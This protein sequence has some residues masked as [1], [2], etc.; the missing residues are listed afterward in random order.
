LSAASG[1][2]QAH[3]TIGNFFNGLHSRT[4]PARKGA[5]IANHELVVIGI[6]SDSGNTGKA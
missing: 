5:K 6:D 4:L 3:Y 1:G 2:A